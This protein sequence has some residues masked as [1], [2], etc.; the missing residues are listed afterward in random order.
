L[1]LGTVNHVAEVWINGV[2]A[3]SR[4]WPPFLFDITQWVKPGENQI[5][6]RVANLVNNSYGDIKPSG[7]T[8]SVYIITS[9]TSKIETR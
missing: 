9:E 3:G 8:G 2:N 1:S 6:I 4:M 7:L 5:R